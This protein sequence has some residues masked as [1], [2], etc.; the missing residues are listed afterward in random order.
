MLLESSVHLLAL[1][2]EAQASRLR[3]VPVIQS[4]SSS[5]NLWLG[6]SDLRSHGLDTSAISWGFSSPSHPFYSVPRQQ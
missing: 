3:R 4:I 5:H 2:A 1:A 6:E